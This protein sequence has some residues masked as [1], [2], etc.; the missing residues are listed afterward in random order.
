MSNATAALIAQK[1]KQEAEARVRNI[2]ITVLVLG[3]LW[4]GVQKFR[5]PTRVVVGSTQTAPK[6]HHAGAA[7]ED[8][9]GTNTSAVG[10]DELF[11]KG[12]DA[13]PASGQ[14]GTIASTGTEGATPG[15]TSS[16]AGPASTTNSGEVAANSTK[17]AAVKIDDIFGDDKL[18]LAGLDATR[19]MY[20]DKDKELLTRA[21]D[22]GA[23]SSYRDMLTRS[24]QVAL[25]Q[26]R[27]GEGRS[28]Y[29][30]FWK[31]PMFYQAILRWEI[32]ITSSRTTFSRSST[33][34]TPAPCSPG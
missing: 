27:Q 3:G 31:T 1:R 7:P 33:T 34:T 2:L 11:K 22:T 14:S 28:R 17:R 16:E 10:Y 23:W 32:P 30:E 4:F 12:P 13:S 5:A 9:E 6:K 15:G 24:M 20:L 18:P 19:Q 25:P 21:W 26:M 29:D 8:E